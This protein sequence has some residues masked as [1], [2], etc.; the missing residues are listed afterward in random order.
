MSFARLR[1]LGTLFFHRCLGSVWGLFCLVGEWVGLH[2]WSG[3]G[4]RGE[5]EWGMGGLDELDEL[6]CALV[7]LRACGCV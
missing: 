2:G 5:M 6:L 1:L 3:G 4:G 7:F